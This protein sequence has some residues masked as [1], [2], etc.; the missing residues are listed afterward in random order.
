MVLERWRSGSLRPLGPARELADMERLMNE[1]FA[2]WPLR[3]RRVPAEEM[4]WAPSLEMYEKE[5]RFVVRVELPGV[6][7]EDIDIS[8]TGEILTIRGERKAPTEISV[9]EYHRCEVCYGLFSRSI[10]VPAAVDA[11]KVEATY[12]EGV[13]EVTMPKAK[14]AVPAKIEIKTR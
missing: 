11:T 6:K 4:A 2:G 9:E 14:E 13:L 10:T 8:M 12:S 5:D 7:R 1:A 3:W